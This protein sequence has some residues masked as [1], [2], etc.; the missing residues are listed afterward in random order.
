M[1]S[2][3]Y[4]FINEVTE[5]YDSTI[6]QDNPK[7]NISKVMEKFSISRTKALKILITSGAV[8]TSLH[9][10]IMKLKEEGYDVDEIA[11]ALNIS[12]TTVKT[13]MPYEKVIYGGKMKSAGALYT[14]KYRTR[15][16]IFMDKVVRQKIRTVEQLEQFCKEANREKQLHTLLSSLDTGFKEDIVH[17]EPYFTKEERK[18]FKIFPA[19]T[20]LHIELDAVISKAH[21]K[22][23]GIRYGKTISRDILVPLDLPLHNLHYMINQ[24][25]GFT[26]SHLHRFELSKEDY[27]WVTDGKSENWKKLI[28][29]VFKNPQRSEELDFWDDDYDGGSPKKWMRS[30]YTGPEYRKH[31]QESYRYIREHVHDLK[32]PD[33]Y[34]GSQY[35]VNETLGIENILYLRTYKRGSVEEWYEELDKNMN[36]AEYYVD[37]D[38]RSQPVVPGFAGKLVYFYDYGDGWQFNITAKKSVEDLIHDGR[39]TEKQVKEA[40][41]KVSTLARPY[42]LAYDGY[43]LVDDCGGTWGYLQLLKDIEAGNPE[44]IDWADWMGWKKKVDVL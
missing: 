29:L 15:E 14:E 27:Q 26:N 17:L 19:V 32:D 40:I 8:D 11:E 38:M 9:H 1:K 44:Q 34:I 13:N 6:D 5:Y 25:F 30:K 36:D 10:E 23:C 20:L 37:Q 35:E 24:A 16:K 7:G 39:V 31:F 33:C 18:L 4:D 43:P 12:V 3:D 41:K 28:G 21:R 22:R 42:M 2:N